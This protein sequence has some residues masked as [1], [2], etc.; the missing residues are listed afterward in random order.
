MARALSAALAAAL[1]AACGEPLLYA[2]MEV[3]SVAVTQALPTLPGSPQVDAPTT[4]LPPEGFDLDLGEIDLGAESEKSSVTLNG[5]LFEI[6]DP[7]SPETTFAGI[8]RAELLI[9]P[10]AGS[11]EPPV[12]LALYDRDRD[13]P[14]TT[15]L[16]LR[17]VGPVNLLPY[18]SANQVKAQVIVGGIPPGPAGGSWT[19]DL[20][21]DMHLLARTELR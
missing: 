19:A 12:T 13:G 17:P 16:A 10:A 3:A 5:A 15:R 9:L 18:L 21:V 8:R 20:T 4:P 7:T 2:E 6:T 11:V 14:A 1:L